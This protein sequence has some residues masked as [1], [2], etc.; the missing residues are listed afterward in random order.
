MA[1]HIGKTEMQIIDMARRMGFVSVIDSSQHDHVFVGGAPS[2]PDGDTVCI[3]SYRGDWRALV[4]S[5]IFVPLHD[6]ETGSDDQETVT[7]Q[8]FAL[9]VESGEATPDLSRTKSG[10][11]GCH[12]YRG[13]D[14]EA[15]FLDCSDH[16]WF[17]WEKDER[18]TFGKLPKGVGLSVVFKSDWRELRDGEA[19]PPNYH[20][21]DPWKTIRNMMRWLGDLPSMRVELLPRTA[22]DGQAIADAW[23][24]FATRYLAE[25]GGQS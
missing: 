5:R 14:G 16:W 13:I 3:R 20:D 25:K 18:A 21:P 8:Y 9:N 4:R 10:M 19:S 17:Y 15:F 23:R 12:E 2:F 6:P 11:T 24:S 22:A 7:I 1:R